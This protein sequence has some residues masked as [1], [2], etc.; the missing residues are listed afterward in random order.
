MA[1]RIRIVATKAEYETAPYYVAPKWDSV[2]KEFLTGQQHMTDVEK[3]SLVFKIDEDTSIP[4]KHGMELNGDNP[5]DKEI[6]KFL[7]HVEIVSQTKS[8]V[9]GDYHRFY[10]ENKDDEAKDSIGKT[11]L[12]LECYDYIRTLSLKEMAD[13]ARVLG[14]RVSNMSKSQ[15]EAAIY[16]KVEDDPKFVCDSIKDSDLKIK[17]FIDK[18]IEESVVVY[19]ASKYYYGDEMIAINKDYLAEYVKDKSNAPVINQWAKL[20]DPDSFKKVKKEKKSIDI[21]D[22]TIKQQI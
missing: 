16:E 9:N 11:N 4:I 12:K 19:K 1:N 22:Q 7:K 6:I 17:I 8:E 21:V 14:T 10:I 13:F 18:L 3:E 2:A 5:T 20:I 15:I